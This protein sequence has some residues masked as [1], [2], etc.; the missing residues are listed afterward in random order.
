MKELT[1]AEEQV[2]RILWKLKECIVKDILDMM[3]EPKPAYSTV[4]TVVRVLQGKGFINH[5]AYGN[6]HV[7]FPAI[8]EKD[9]KHFAFDKIMDVFFDNSYQDL[10]S[11][12]VHEKN[13][14]TTELAKLTQLVHELKNKKP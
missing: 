10:V 11:F 8:E 4:S 13:I 14:G 9:Y 2:M 12:L 5:K 1:K 3:P 6:S 7:Y